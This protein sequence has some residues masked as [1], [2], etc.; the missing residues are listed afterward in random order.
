M[1]F[2]KKKK[3]WI[4]Q[5]ISSFVNFINSRLF[6]KLLSLYECFSLQLLYHILLHSNSFH[7]LMENV[8][9]LLF[10]WTEQTIEYVCVIWIEMFSYNDNTHIVTYN[11]CNPTPCPGFHFLIESS[12]C[13][14]ARNGQSSFRTFKICALICLFIVSILL[15]CLTSSGYDIYSHKWCT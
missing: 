6:E 15:I 2:H 12:I 11:K 9:Y 8:H 7:N 13:Y 1:I 10:I 4:G 3:I 5:Y 14:F